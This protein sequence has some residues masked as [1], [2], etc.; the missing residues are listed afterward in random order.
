V[1]VT[2]YCCVYVH[3]TPWNRDTA[4]LLCPYSS[5]YYIITLHIIKIYIEGVHFMIVIYELMC[6]C[7]L[8]ITRLE[9]SPRSDSREQTT[10]SDRQ[11]ARQRQIKGS[12]DALSVI[13]SFILSLVTISVVISST[14]KTPKHTKYI[15]Q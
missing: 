5:E 6:T 9:L 11:Q 7:Q 1:L 8:P 2:A 4:T 13:L 14:T 15:F 12:P 3:T 10:C